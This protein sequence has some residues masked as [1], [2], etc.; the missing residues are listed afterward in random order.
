[1]GTNASGWYIRDTADRLVVKPG[2][3][4]GLGTA[5]PVR[6]LHVEGGEIHSGG[7]SGGFSFSNR[8]H[9]N[10]VEQP[11]AGER[12]LWYAVNGEARLWSG[13]DVLGIHPVGSTFSFRI[14]GSL[15]TAVR[16][17]RGMIPAGFASEP[18]TIRC[19]TMAVAVEDP[20]AP[21]TVP[22]T[23]TELSRSAHAVQDPPPPIPAPT[24][25]VPPRIALFHDFAMDQKDG[26][27]IN[28]R[29]R[30]ADG[31]KI[32]GNVQVT[33]V[34]TQ[35]SSSALE[36]NISELS[37]E[38]AMATLQGLKAVK[39]HYKADRQQQQHIGFIAEDVPDILATPERDRLSPM[40]IIAV[41]TKAVQEL[42]EEV[43]SLKE[44]NR[45]AHA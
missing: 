21:L 27:V 43:R 23:A 36:E 24:I 17:L 22:G 34:F 13:K 40:D 45:G 8:S 16:E 11:S 4:V 30:Y 15:E 32:E 12:W 6:R 26:L 7:P 9:P 18:S 5:N 14:H 31:V 29:G 39:F 35:A 44:R 19:R 2:G 10:F 28:H 41:L 37:G 33:G 25:P 3:N 1:V 20:A 38:E 42:S